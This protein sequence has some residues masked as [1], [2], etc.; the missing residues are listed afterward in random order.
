MKKPTPVPAV[1]NRQPQRNVAQPKR[2]VAPPV[3]RPQP[4]PKVLQTKKSPALPP[5]TAA[6]ATPKPIP[7]G[8]PQR[9]KGVVNALSNKLANQP[10]NRPVQLKTVVPVSPPK[11]V[12]PARPTTT[13]VIAKPGAAHQQKPPATL[14]TKSRTI[15][16]PGRSPNPLLVQRKL[17]TSPGQVVQP[18]QNVI[19]RGRTKQTRKKRRKHAGTHYGSCEFSSDKLSVARAVFFDRPPSNSRRGQG[20]HIVSY[21][22]ITQTVSTCV[23]GKAL[24]EAGEELAELVGAAKGFVKTGAINSSW[25]SQADALIGRLNAIDPA[26][27][28]AAQ[29]GLR[30]GI[31][32]VLKLLNIMP[33]TAM[34][35]V[36]S[37]GGHGEGSIL[38]A[39][40]K[41]KAGKTLSGNIWVNVLKMFDGAADRSLME[42]SA[43]LDGKLAWLMALFQRAAPTIYDLIEA[44]NLTLI[45]DTDLDSAASAKFGALKGMEVAGTIQNWID[46]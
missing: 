29:G 5:R 20:D 26:D 35:N 6:P 45:P 7:P 18:A 32:D 3:Y 8:P 16:P 9:P 13:P 44:N 24:D 14:P 37:T 4:V 30:A 28:G 41:V 42:D 25:H 31:N 22:L 33:G 27:P 36:R 38:E 17:N 15:I 10:A 1:N 46:G 2:P 19:Q 39:E 43:R 40:R 23:R 11:S 21:S 34:K 12:R